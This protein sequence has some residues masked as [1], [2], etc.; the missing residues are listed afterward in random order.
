M[1]NENVIGSHSLLPKNSIDTSRPI[2]MDNLMYLFPDLEIVPFEIPMTSPWDAT[3][4]DEMTARNSM[5]SMLS[6]SLSNLVPSCGLAHIF[7]RYASYM[8]NGPNTFIQNGEGVWEI[9]NFGTLVECDQRR[10]EGCV[11]MFQEYFLMELV[12]ILK[13]VRGDFDLMAY[14][15]ASGYILIDLNYKDDFHRQLGEGFY[16][17]SSRLGGFINPMLTDLNTLN[18]NATQLEALVTNTI[19]RKMGI[20]GSQYPLFESQPEP[21]MTGSVN[22]IIT[23]Q[24]AQPSLA[25]LSSSF[26]Y[27][28]LI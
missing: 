27:S 7:F 19:G 1:F 3:P 18:H 15:D 23:P 9:I 24:T 5:S 4:Q 10:Q 14:V 6:A 28:S 21:V 26:D 16:E 20:A 13:L 22:G 8:Q 2:S 11:R 17:T 12:P 25:P